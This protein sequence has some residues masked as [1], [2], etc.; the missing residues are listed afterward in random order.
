[1]GLLDGK[2]AI[3]T[4]GGR[5][6]GRAEALLFAREGALVVVNDRGAERNGDGNDPAVAEA[7]AEEIRAAGGKAIANGD[8]VA[9]EAGA[10]S[11]V[12][13]AVEA[14]GQVDVLVCSA[15]IVVDRGV[16]KLEKSAW[17]AAVDVHLTGTF[18]C[19]QAFARRVLAQGTGGRIVTTT[20]PSALLGNFG[21]AGYT[22]A[23]AGIYGLTRTLAVELQRHH[24]TVNALAAVA[25]TR[26]TEDLPM[27]HRIDTLT[28]EHV[29]PAALYLASPLVGDRTGHVLAA[30][31]ARMYAFKLVESTGR[32]K[33]TD[34]GV[35]TAQEIADNWDGIVK[36]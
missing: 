1:M 31:G 36:A 20:H 3:V 14:F 23:A 30:A 15:G 12:G 9:T 34:D 2:V 29:A 27:F 22:A 25:K 7:V 17:D 16:T 21:Q 6:I 19:A 11:V 8:S 33:E 5:G 35:W 24:I 28:P 10:T 26:L 13:A 4:G 18:L 32:F